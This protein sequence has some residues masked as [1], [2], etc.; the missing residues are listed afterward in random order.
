MIRTKQYLFKLVIPFIRFP[1]QQAF[2][3][4]GSAFNL[5]NNLLEL[6]VSKPLIVT[7]R[8][9]IRLNL[10]DEFVE[11]LRV[12]GID[13]IIFNH[14]QPDPTI[15]NVMEG[16]QVYVENQCNGIIA[17]GG[18]S[19]IDCAKM[20]GAKAT[21]Q[22]SVYG[23]KG[24]FKVKN[25]IPFLLAIP[26]TAGTGTESTVAAVITNEASAE[27]FVIN[28]TKLIPK[29]YC[30]DPTLLVT[31][32]NHLTASTGMDALTHAI[33]A[34]IGIHGT[35]QTNEDAI[36][37]VQVI[38]NTLEKSY[39]NGNQ[40]E[41]RLMM[42]KAANDA[43]KAFTKASVGYVHAIAHQ[44]GALYH[45]PHG[46]ANAIVLPYVL[47]I[48]KDKARKK[49]AHLGKIVGIPSVNDEELADLFIQKVRDLNDVLAIPKHITEIRERD[50]SYLALK[51]EQ[52]A[53]P[54]YPVPKI[55][56]QK[57]FEILLKRIRGDQEKETLESTSLVEEI[58]SWVSNH[59]N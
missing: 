24:M 27:K 8:N 11:S 30:L 39:K 41:D 52:E 53:N 4:Q 21:N 49:L 50:I 56:Y 7:D 44:L 25:K 12:T 35:K 16:V 13:Y 32:P 58:N 51:I 18:G 29:A 47:E 22:K 23:M 3:G 43:G 55:L 19:C 37:A 9:L 14:V 40:L 10:M 6:G 26:T 17:I 34:Y 31:L 2:I 57:D 54:A 46:L 48:S 59:E 33:E 1:E 28:D 45:I 42:L 20:I 38:F 5:A 36:K 15:S